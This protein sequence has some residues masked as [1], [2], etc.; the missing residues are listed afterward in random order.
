[1]QSHEVPA[2]P[3]AATH[4]NKVPAAQDPPFWHGLGPLAEIRMGYKILKYQTKYYFHATNLREF[5]LSFDPLPWG[6]GMGDAN[7]LIVSIAIVKRLRSIENVFIFNFQ[8]NLKKFKDM[9]R[10]EYYSH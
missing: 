2:S 5:H 1:M 6:F 10:F 9:Q 4:C 8:M 7:K 3:L